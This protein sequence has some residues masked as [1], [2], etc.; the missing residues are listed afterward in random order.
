MT[1]AATILADI[2]ETGPGTGAE[3]AAT[4]GLDARRVIGHL[5]LLK[6]DGLVEVV[7]FVPTRTARARIYGAR[8]A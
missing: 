2:L 5:M 7:G 6:R 4:L 1:L 8:H 3:I